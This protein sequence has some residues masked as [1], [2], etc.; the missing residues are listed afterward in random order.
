M[1]SSDKTPWQIWTVVALL[2]MEGLGNLLAIA[3]TPAA[4]FWLAAKCLFITGL[5]N[6]WKWVFALFLIIAGMHVL[7][8]NMIGPIGSLMNLILIALVASTYRTF[9]PPKELLANSSMSA[10]AT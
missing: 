2:S 6:R 3:D 4:A 5:I 10:R 1:V 9:F 7:A 8:I